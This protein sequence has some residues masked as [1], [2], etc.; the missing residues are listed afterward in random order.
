MIV[1]NKNNYRLAL[2]ILLILFSPIVSVV[3]NLSS[4]ST[5]LLVTF[6]L[7]PFFNNYKIFPPKFNK[8]FFIFLFFIFFEIIKSIY[9]Q[10]SLFNVLFVIVGFFII[11]MI[12]YI[13]YD[14][15]V[16]ENFEGSVKIILFIIFNLIIFSFCNIKIGNYDLYSKSV[17]PLKE[18]SH[19]GLYFGY[20]F[21]IA[22][23]FCKNGLTKF[24]LFIFLSIFSLYLEN[25]L[26]IIITLVSLLVSNYNNKRNLMFVFI[27]IIFILFVII[28]YSLFDFKYYEERLN[29]TEATNLSVL[30]LFQG[31]EIITTTLSSINFFGVGLNN[32]EAIEPGV[33][34]E[35]I[36][37]VTDKYF[38]R[39]DGGFLAAKI[40]G[41]MGWLGAFILFMYIRFVISKLKYLSR[42]YSVLD[43]FYSSVLVISLLE[44]FLRGLGYF[45]IGT[46]LITSSLIYFKKN[47]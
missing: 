30:A 34:S 10:S 24:L 15:S 35:M 4:Y 7:V 43:Y 12:S 31:W 45:T 38:N 41:E 3:L 32:L 25:F 16:N 44:L 37:S 5:S 6:F 9:F 40:I 39:N 21:P 46:I 2:I 19:F 14:K 11:F 29:F 42:S 22:F 17:F 33:Y 18:P 26:L 13:I 8:Y 23:Y 20:F 36:Y 28:K 47:D 27:L 1:L